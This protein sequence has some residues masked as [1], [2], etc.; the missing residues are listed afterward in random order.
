[1][2]RAEMRFQGGPSTR[3]VMAQ[4]MDLDGVVGVEQANRA[5]PDEL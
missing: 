1:M 5:D 3:D 2:I 4:L